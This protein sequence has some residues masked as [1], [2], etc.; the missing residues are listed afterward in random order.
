VSADTTIVSFSIETINIDDE[1]D[2]AKS[3]DAVADPSTEMPHKVVS[4]EERVTETPSRT[5][6]TEECPRSGPNSL[7]D[8]GSQ[9]RARK[10]PPKPCKFGIRSA[11]K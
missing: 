8:A 2:D 11:S 10:A 3:L 4:A 5:S 1:E 7:G 9:K 6:M